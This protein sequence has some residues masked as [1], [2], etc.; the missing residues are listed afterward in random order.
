MRSAFTPAIISLKRHGS[1]RVELEPMDRPDDSKSRQSRLRNEKQAK[2]THLS[3]NFR[4][5]RSVGEG[6]METS[7]SRRTRPLI[8]ADA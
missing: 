4:R 5:L 3:V 6:N 8:T 1:K 2:V 7:S